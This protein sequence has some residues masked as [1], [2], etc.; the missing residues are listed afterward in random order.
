[1]IVY[2]FDM[3]CGNI[4]DINECT[5]NGRLCHNGHCVNTEGSYRC[6]CDTGFQLS[7]DGAFCL[8][9][10]PFLFLQIL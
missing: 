7:P 10:G 3:P 2:I 8:G 5:E 9:M 4:T 1:M 6:E